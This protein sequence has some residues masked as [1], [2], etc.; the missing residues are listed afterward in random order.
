MNEPQHWAQAYAA[1][2]AAGHACLPPEALLAAWDEGA[3]ATQRAAAIAAMA[4]CAQCA[5]VGQIARDLQQ[6]LAEDAQA[7]APWARPVTPPAPLADGGPAVEV[8]GAAVPRPDVARSAQQH[9]PRHNAR[10]ATRV[11]R[12]AAAAVVLLAVGTVSWLLRA[13]AEAPAI[14]GEATTPVTPA[15][16]S[17]LRAAPAQ[18]QWTAI[19]TAAAYQVELYDETAQSLWRSERI[20]GTTVELPAAVRAQLQRGTFLWRVRA[21]GSDVEIGPFYFRVEP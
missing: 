7:F 4:E 15:S 8:A 5:A 1:T 6:H 3:A 16:G 2:S 9:A 12:W 17:R 13:P 11:L 20:T 21:E 10:A 19:G 14:R 18:L